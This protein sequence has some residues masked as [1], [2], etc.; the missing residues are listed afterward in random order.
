MYVHG[1]DSKTG[2]DSNTMMFMD[3][4]SYSIQIVLDAERYQD[5]IDWF[6]AKVASGRGRSERKKAAVAR[7]ILKAAM[8]AEKATESQSSDLPGERGLS[9]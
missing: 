7:E 8:D 2:K 3:A 1:R 6:E 9:G 4:K 5:L